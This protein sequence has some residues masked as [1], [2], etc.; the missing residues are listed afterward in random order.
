LRSPKLPIFAAKSPIWVSLRP[1]LASSLQARFAAENE[2]RVAVNVRAAYAEEAAS[3]WL[4][5][6]LQMMATVVITFIAL[7]AVMQKHL[8]DSDAL[9]GQPEPSKTSEPLPAIFSAL[10][11]R[12]ASHRFHLPYASLQGGELHYHGPNTSAHGI[13]DLL[14]RCYEVL[15]RPLR[16]VRRL[17]LTSASPLLG[18]P[19][20]GLVGLGMSYALPIVELL[21]GLLATFTE[22]E[23]EMVAVERVQQ[24][25]RPLSSLEPQYCAWTA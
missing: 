1:S 10:W 17:L 21:N 12:V 11:A 6:R 25:G 18:S 3:K 22:T 23:K 13:G 4:G 14:S 24:V 7:V 15:G 16:G 19:S 20:V 2:A 9:A 8:T 5:M